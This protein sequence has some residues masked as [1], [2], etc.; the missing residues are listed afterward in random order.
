MGCRDLVRACGAVA[1]G[2]RQVIAARMSLGELP[3]PERRALGRG[4]CSGVGVTP[5]T[6]PTSFYTPRLVL[7]FDPVCYGLDMPGTNDERPRRGRP[8]R[9]AIDAAIVR[10]AVELM[11]EGGVDATT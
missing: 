4:D 2:W 6:Y 10:A 8:R 5:A 11:T 7:L 3:R 9:A 1:P